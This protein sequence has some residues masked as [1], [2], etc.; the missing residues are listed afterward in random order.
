MVN[1]CAWKK[2]GLRA[3]TVC[4]MAAIL[5]TVVGATGALVVT[6]VRNMV[7]AESEASSRRLAT[8]VGDAL[9]AFGIAGDVEGLENFL[10]SLDAHGA[11]QDVHA[12]RTEV[13]A[14]DFDA[15]PGA[16]P[17][18][19]AE[20]AVVANGQE[21]KIVDRPAHRIRYVMPI[22]AR[23]ACLSCH[24]SATEGDVLG[25]ASVTARTDEVDAAQA[26]IT[27]VVTGAFLGAIVLTLA[28]L[29]VLIARILI[30]PLTRVAD[31]LNEGAE[32][33]NQA[34]AQISATTESLAEGASEQAASL[35]ESS[36]ALEELAASTQTNASRAT[37]AS[38]VAERSAHTARDGNET[39]QRLNAAMAAIDDS[40]GKI[41]K[42]VRVIEDIAFQTNLLAL[43]AAVEAARAGDQGKGFAVVAGE[44]RNLAGRVTEAVGEITSL[45]DESNERAHEGVGVAGSVGTALATML[46]DVTEVSGLVEGIARACTEQAQGVVQINTAVGEMDKVTQQNASGAEEFAAAAEELSSQAESVRGVAACLGRLIHGTCG[47]DAARADDG[48]ACGEL[49]AAQR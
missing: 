10:T 45:I 16:D 20:R 24:V 21:Q 44:V 12:V 18:D 30:R 9:L 17:R 35:E 5:L 1:L 27:R 37:S 34:A 11:V 49:I 29:S 31:A 32:Q 23:E 39:V 43:N 22:L 6:R 13:V 14:R 19:D 28:I 25:V 42:I 15:R 36:A 3:R 41:G 26:G 40:A 8:A 2:M 46:A 4:V 38:G 47:A 33:V 48:T 7:A